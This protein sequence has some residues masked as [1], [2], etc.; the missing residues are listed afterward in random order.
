MNSFARK[1]I[2]YALTGAF[3]LLLA[4]QDQTV[5]WK[6]SLQDLEHR[7]AALPAQ[8]GS[9]GLRS[10]AEA[11]R[12]ALADFAATHPEMKLQVPEALPESPTHDAMAHQLEQLNA[13]VNQVVQHT[14][15]TPFDLGH[16]EVNVT[17]A[18][19]EQSPVTVGIDQTEISNL[20]LV[21]AAKALDYLPGVSIQHLSANPNEAGIMVRGFSTRARFLYTSIAFRFRFPTTAMS[22]SIAI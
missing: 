21:N 4:Q 2:L 18:V 9:G 7:L 20:Y 22:I 13:A 16:V 11:L 14:P 15:G 3:V 10:D 17:A 12:S 5:Q 19:V 1:L 8:T 6:Q